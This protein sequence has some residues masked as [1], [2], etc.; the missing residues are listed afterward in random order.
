MT[1]QSMA[2]TDALTILPNGNIGIATTAPTQKLDVQGNVH[3]NGNINTQGT[4]KAQELSVTNYIIT[5]GV[6]HTKLLSATGSINTQGK[7][8]EN[9]H[10]LIPRGTIIMWHGDSRT[11]PKGWAICN[12]QNGTP[13]LRDR[14]IVGAGNTYKVNATGGE[15]RVSL[16]INEMPR[17]SH[18]V[19]TG[20]KSMGNSYDW[21]KKGRYPA[22]WDNSTYRITDEKGNGDS[23]ENR[24]PYYALYFLMKL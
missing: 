21:D 8:K 20:V 10:D 22:H 1:V 2:Q 13:D 11:I 7:V 5:Q 9:H 14:F 4:I 19:F 3:V 6:I 23:H 16:K 18:R 15:E 17:H 12:K 24:P